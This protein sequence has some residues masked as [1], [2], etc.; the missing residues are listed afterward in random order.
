MILDNAIMALTFI[1]SAI[2][3][4]FA[5]K[6]Q[7]HEEQGLDAD[8]IKKLYESLGSEQKLRLELRAEFDAYRVSM[9]VRM[10]EIECEN[11]KLRRWAKRMMKQLEDA[12]IVPVKFDE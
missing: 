10:A 4:F 8:T 3:L 5:L 11:G 2:A 1:S 6:K 12:G 9:N 7:K